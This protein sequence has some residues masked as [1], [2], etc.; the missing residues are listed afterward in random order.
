MYKVEALPGSSVLLL[1]SITTR[2]CS[3]DAVIVLLMAREVS[4][5]AL[6]KPRA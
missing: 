2:T 3:H 4:A 5:A 6:V 1:M